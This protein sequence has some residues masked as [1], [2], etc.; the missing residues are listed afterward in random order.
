M[1]MKN[2]I[3]DLL[4]KGEPMADCELAELL[5]SPQPSVRR[6]RQQLVAELKVE[7]Q[8]EIDGT[9]MWGIRGLKIVKQEA[10]QPT[11]TP[12]WSPG[13]EN[14]KQARRQEIEERAKQLQG[15]TRLL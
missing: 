9:K 7:Q 8:G 13:S 5:E 10:T 2:K 1:S 11:D 14:D 6:A 4:K 15:G 12:G 3:L